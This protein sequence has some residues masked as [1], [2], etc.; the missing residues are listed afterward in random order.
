[1]PTDHPTEKLLVVPCSGIGKVRGLISLE[2]VYRVTDTL[3]PEQ[4]ETL[5]LPLSLAGEEQERRF[6]REHPT[7]AV[8]GCD[9][10]CAKRGT[11]QHSGQVAAVAVLPLVF[12]CVRKQGLEPGEDSAD[13]LLEMVRVYHAIEPGYEAS[14]R[15]AVAEAYQEFCQG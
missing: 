8:D 15:V 14:Y 4:A 2:A 9:R 7:I 6:A 13:R 12:D 10:L 1:M 3:M 11:E 5:C